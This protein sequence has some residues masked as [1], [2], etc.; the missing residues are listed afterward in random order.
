MQVRFTEFQESFGRVSVEQ[1]RHQNV[2][3]READL[4]SDQVA[5]EVAQQ[6]T[7]DLTR[8][9]P[10][11]ETEGAIVNP[12][13]ERPH[14]FGHSSGQQGRQRQGRQRQSQATPEETQGRHIDLTA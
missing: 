12:D 1:A 14:L 8:P 9:V 4:G 13:Q 11:T 2:L 6:Q 5:R 10:T 7:L 3:L